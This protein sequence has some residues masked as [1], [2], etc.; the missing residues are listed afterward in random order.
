MKT[1]SHFIIIKALLCLFLT[2]PCLLLAFSQTDTSYYD[3]LQDLLGIDPVIS[4]D[5]TLDAL[6]G[7]RLK[8]NGIAVQAVWTDEADFTDPVD[9]LGQVV[10]LP[11]L[12]AASL[13]GSLNLLSS[14]LAFRRVQTDPVLEAPLP[15]STDGYSVGGMCALRVDAVDAAYYMWYTGVPENGYVQRLYLATSDD[16]VVWTKEATPVIG[17][18]DPGSFDSR[19]IGKPSVLYDPLNLEAPFRMWYSAEGD[20]GGSIGYAT[21]LDGRTWTK[22]G[23]V[24]VP[25]LIG[26]ADS[27]SISQPSVILDAGIYRMW[28]TASDSNNLRVA[29]ATSLEGLTW[30]RGGVVID[31]GS[32]TGNYDTGA[33]S[34][35]V[36][37]SDTGFEMIF[38]GGK[39]VSED[40]IQTKLITASSP[41]GVVWTPGNIALN[42]HKGSFDGYNLSQPHVIHDPDDVDRPYKMWYVG[43]NPDD[44]GNYHDRVGYAYGDDG[45]HWTRVSGGTGDPYYDSVLTLGDQSVAF[46]SMNVAD[47]RP[48]PI[49]AGGGLYGFYTGTNAADFKQRIGVVQ[50]VDDGLSWTDLGPSHGDPLIDAGPADSF[51]EGGVATPAPVHDGTQWVIYH[52]SLDSSLDAVLGLHL[53]ADDLSSVTRVASPVLSSGTGFD[54]DGCADPSV[55]V[56]GT[57][58]T[59]FYAGLDT[60]TG[61]W[62]IGAATAD[63]SAPETLTRVGQILAPEPD[64][65]DAGGLRHPMV[66]LDGATWHLWYSAVDSD[67]VERTAYST[68]SD[69]LVWTK[70]GLALVPS[71]AAYDFTERAVRPSG[72][73]KTDSLLKLTFTGS[74]RFGWLRCGTASATGSGFIDGGTASYQLDNEEARDWRRILWTE[75]VP[76]DTDQEVWVSYFPTYSGLWSEYLRVD[77]DT[78]LPFRLTVQS[79]VW[80]VRMTSLL[81][82][83]SPRLDDLTVNHAPISFPDYGRAVTL[84]IGAPEGKYILGWG[85]LTLEADVPLDTTSLGVAVEDQDGTPLLESQAIT[86]GILNTFP[87]SD[88]PA[89]TGRLRL[90]F[91][92]TGDTLT[93]A[94]LKNFGVTYTSTDTPADLILVSDLN[95]IVLGESAMVTG[96]LISDTL[97]L[98]DQ[99]VVLRYRATTETVF[100]DMDPQLTGLDGTLTFPVSPAVNT[101]YRAE[102]AGGDVGG[103]LYPPA[104]GS[105]LLE[106]QPEVT[107]ALKAFDYRQKKYFCYAQGSRVKIRGKVNPD[108]YLEGDGVTPGSVAVAIYKKKR[109]K[110]DGSVIWVEKAS[111]VCSLNDNSKYSWR[112]KARR[113]G[114]YRVQTTFLGDA[115][116]AACPSKFRYLRIY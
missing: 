12:D 5:V 92:F 27:F 41:D 62:S 18:G 23:E 98:A 74:D 32:G 78:D 115:D 95:P 72:A 107:L 14:P 79:M 33:W 61:L 105:L 25:G 45:R 28:Y 49:P 21:S 84:P 56:Q 75:T 43:N 39:T 85:D 36:W 90:I 60:S 4:Q 86:G 64:T 63:I 53:A 111:K 99:T 59:I 31:A 67:G 65:A 83:A 89:T 48:V 80:Q 71:T 113:R 96:L 93:T 9:P 58:L 103:T 24:F 69:G 110:V 81:P 102:W 88:L 87:L 35:T 19:Q 70:Q 108:H 114:R 6:G 13:P 20:F 55:V 3:G 30:Q 44:N 47:L 109:S 82:A 101:V 73:W 52:T 100:T 116:H 106:V 34:P 50:S 94:K 37:K 11:T 46:D 42:P 40:E 54:S 104:V 66:L 77:N 8:T 57:A 2:V 97:P 17:T 10:G 29:F 7:V 15:L 91:E 22:V 68:S 1:R 51:D 16:G 38:T 76:V 112:W 26:M